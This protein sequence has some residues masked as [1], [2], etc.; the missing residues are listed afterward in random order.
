MGKTAITAGDIYVNQIPCHVYKYDPKFTW[1]Y[2]EREEIK[3]ERKRKRKKKEERKER[4]NR[5][6]KRTNIH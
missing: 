2:E 6:Q 5:K 3:K 4:N 1:Y